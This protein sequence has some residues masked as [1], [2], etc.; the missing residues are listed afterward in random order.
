[1]SAATPA[2]EAWPAWIALLLLA[3]LAWVV[4]LA[5]ALAMADCSCA[6][7]MGMA[8]GWFLAMWVTM[9]AG[10]MFPGLAPVAILWTR[11]IVHRG[12]RTATR[13][14]WFVSGYLL[15]WT[16]AGVVAFAAFA[17]F[18]RLLAA[19]GEGAGW[20][21]AAVFALAGAYQFTPLKDVCLRHC[22]SPMGL[23][24]HY[25]GLRG[26]AIDLRVG[27]HNGL[28]CIGCCWGLMAILLAVGVMNLGV[29]AA[30]TALIFLE[31]TS[32]HTRLIAR[33]TG[34][35]LLAAALLAALYPTLFPGLSL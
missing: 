35:L 12:E 34:A 25:T 10:M 26:P 27:L 5:Q 17:G 23:L 9:M 30:L 28:Y 8:F 32:N 6:G 4:T 29:M 14:A 33:A 21:G 13:I 7:T 3:A 15:A 11:A 24:A 16:A 2:R 18:E 20:L 1:M 19:V 31:K 22:R